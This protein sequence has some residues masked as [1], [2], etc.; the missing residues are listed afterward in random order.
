MIH[1]KTFSA[2]ALAFVLVAGL[3]TAGILYAQN[4][5]DGMMHGDSTRMGGMMGMMSMMENCPMMGAM[6]QGP[7]AA[8]GHREELGLTGQQ[9]QKLE[10]LAE[11][12]EQARTEAMERM[13]TVHDEIAAATEGEAFNEAAM[14]GAFDRMG[15]LHTEMGVAMLRTRHEV[16]QTLTPEQRDEL[17]DLGGGMMGWAE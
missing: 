16:R 10:V 7:G 13:M 1:K 9:V 11:G 6:V 4:R 3:A 2:L 12:A 5:M 8:L 15:N 14:R 17:A